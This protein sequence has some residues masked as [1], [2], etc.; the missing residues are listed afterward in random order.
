[1]SQIPLNH[2][3][4]NNFVNKR[5]YNMTKPLF[6]PLFPFCKAGLNQWRCSLK[7]LLVS[8]GKVPLLNS[9][10]NQRNSK[11]CVPR[12][13]Q[14]AKLNE[15]LDIPWVFPWISSQSKHYLVWD[16]DLLGGLGQKH[17]SSIL[18][19]FQP[20]YGCETGENLR[21]PENNKLDTGLMKGQ[22]VAC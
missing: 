13:D 2:L 22:S 21:L 10:R 14:T 9:F 15:G 17:D 4:T 6:P 1:M 20:V 5:C 16:W 8:S 11:Q 12:D 18:S 3:N 19:I 7:V